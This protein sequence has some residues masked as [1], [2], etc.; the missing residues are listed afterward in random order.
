M[1]L[2]DVKSVISDEKVQLVLFLL[3]VLVH[4]YNEIGPCQSLLHPLC[5]GF[6]FFLSSLTTIV[7][8]YQ[9]GKYYKPWKPAN[10]IVIVSAKQQIAELSEA[11]NLSQRAV[12]AD[13]FGFKH[14]MNKLQ[15]NT[16]DHKVVRTRLYGRLLQVN[17]PGHLN[18]LYPHLVA[19]LDSSLSRELAEARVL[20]DGV[21]LPVA[22]TVRRLASR[23]MS[24][25]FFGESLSSNEAF[26]K[27]LLRYPQDMVKCMGAFQITPA[28]MSPV[29]HALLTKRGEAMNLIQGRLFEYMGPGRSTWDEPDQTKYLT[30]MHN[31]TEL[32]ESSDYWNPEL[33][34]QS[35]LGIWFAAAH[36]PWMNLHFIMIELCTRPQWQE[37]LRQEIQQHSTLDYKTLEGLPLLDSFIKETVRLKPLDTLAIRRKAL[38]P[39]SFA[40]G[41]LSVPSGATVCVSAYDLMHDT[42]TYAEP[43]SFDPTR[44]LPKDG[45]SQRKFTEVSETFP[46]WGYGSLACPGRLHASLAMKMVMAT[47]ISR[48]DMR[49]EDPNAR[50]RWSWETF[51]M[52]YETT[53]IVFKER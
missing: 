22:Q 9:S 23:L 21:S 41:S 10:P 33:L 43:N 35:L 20:Q 49:L 44:F 15:H 39:H 11:P 1:S 16:S 7:R 38:G 31:M 26:S 8:D 6:A 4:L 46:V 24:L 51:T 36:Q 45:K 5:D 50:T 2:V 14:T 53:R 52:P 12:Y 19:R 18:A 13:M 27:A 25:M 3:V 47:L 17:G 30:I 48:Y 37:A 40:H 34:S 32:T 42:K 29:V 28:F